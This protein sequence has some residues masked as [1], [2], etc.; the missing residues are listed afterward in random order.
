MPGKIEVVRIADRRLADPVRE[1]RGLAVVGHDFQGHRAEGLEGP[2]LAAEEPFLAL[3][4]GKLHV[5]PATVAQ[6]EDKEAQCPARPADRNRAGRAPVDLR[7]LARRVSEGQIRRG[8]RGPHRAHVVAHDGAA[9]DVALLAQ[10]LPELRRGEGMLG[11]PARDRRL[12]PIQDTRPPRRLPLLIARPAD[13]FFHG[14]G[15]QAQGAR[16]LRHRQVLF[17]PPLPEL[18]KRLIGDHRAP[19]R[20]TGA[21]VSRSPGSSE[22]T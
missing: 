13:P 19:S 11:E 16:D 15:M 14:L 17:V 20:P 8:T 22:S 1:H 12:V 21:G 4:E 2:A 18:A 6:H 3:A 7:A 10:A 5:E 9:A